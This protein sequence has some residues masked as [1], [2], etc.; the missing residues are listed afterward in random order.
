M[1][2]QAK[3]VRRLH[4]QALDQVKAQISELRSSSSVDTHAKDQGGGD[5]LHFAKPQLSTGS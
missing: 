1:Y 3:E 4:Q 2:P 5:P